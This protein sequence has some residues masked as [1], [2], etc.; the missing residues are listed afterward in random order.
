[1]T[2]KSLTWRVERKETPKDKKEILLARYDCC[3]VLCVTINMMQKIRIESFCVNP[4]LL[5]PIVIHLS[6]YR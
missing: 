1:M 5:F 4:F 2:Q 3:V 6:N